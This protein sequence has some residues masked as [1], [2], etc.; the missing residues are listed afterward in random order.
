MSEPLT[1]AQ[2]AALQRERDIAQRENARWVL[3]FRM[4]C[5]EAHQLRAELTE[6]GQALTKLTR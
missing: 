2:V 6:I 1:R 4:V 5:E 3:L